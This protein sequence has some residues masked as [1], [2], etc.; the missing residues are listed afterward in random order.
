MQKFVILSFTLVKKYDRRITA[1]QLFLYAGEGIYNFLP[2]LSKLFFIL[3][4]ADSEQKVITFLLA[5]R[6]NKSNIFNIELKFFWSWRWRTQHSYVLKMS[7]Y[8]KI[9]AVK[10]SL[11]FKVLHALPL[12]HTK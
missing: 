2:R 11:L 1:K 5:D 10:Y 9:C 8:L 3:E 6:E 7:K 12:F 4:T